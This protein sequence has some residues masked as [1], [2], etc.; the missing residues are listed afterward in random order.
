M[1]TELPVRFTSLRGNIKLKFFCKRAVYTKEKLTNFWK[2]FIRSRKSIF[3]RFQ[4]FFASYVKIVFSILLFLEIL[5]YVSMDALGTCLIRYL[6][7][8]SK[9]MKAAIFLV[10]WRYV[11][12]FLTFRSPV[13]KEMPR[14][15]MVILSAPHRK[16]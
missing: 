9:T 8:L 11:Y 14:C 15:V 12:L 16:L 7:A 1:P 13:S 5:Y 3:S 10:F 6:M 4:C 2:C